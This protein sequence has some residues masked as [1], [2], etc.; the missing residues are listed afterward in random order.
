MTWIAPLGAGSRRRG[1]HSEP[2]P[3]FDGG[4]REYCWDN[5]T[6]TDRSDRDG[7]RPGSA[8]PWLREQLDMRRRRPYGPRPSVVMLYADPW[9]GMD[10]RFLCR[11]LLTDD[12]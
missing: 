9:R 7:Q 5:P 11:D 1:P 6:R 8:V 10:S 2:I 4:K 3:L 12:V